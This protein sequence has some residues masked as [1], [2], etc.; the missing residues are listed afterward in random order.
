[1]KI[2]ADSEVRYITD[3]VCGANEV[4][5]H[6]CGVNPGIDFT[7]VAY[8]QLRKAEAGDC[9]PVCG[10]AYECFNAVSVGSVL[11]AGNYYTR[12]SNVLTTAGSEKKYLRAAYYYLNLSRITALIVENNMDD[13]GIV[14]PQPAA[15]FSVAVIPVDFNDQIIKNIC[16]EIYEKLSAQDIDVMLDDRDQRAGVKFNDADLV[17]YPFSVIVGKKFT[18]EGL[19]EIKNRKTRG[20]RLLTP[21]EAITFIIKELKKL[22]I[23]L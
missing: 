21:D 15:P 9:C 6:L 8:V 18:S 1:M 2:I 5:Y 19:V 20:R 7:P 23:T 10:K 14:W 22:K 11:N 13:Y 4:D 3:G 12:R 17:G 16:F